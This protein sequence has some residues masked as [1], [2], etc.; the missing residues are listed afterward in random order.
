MKLE[1]AICD[2]EICDLLEEEALLEEVIPIA[3]K[4]VTW[5]IDMFSTSEDMI[6]SNKAYDWVFLDVEMG[7]PN[8]LQTAEMLHE[9]KK[10]T[11]IFF[12]THHEDYMDQAL[13][14]HAFRFWTK[15]MDK[16]RLEYGLKV[17]LKKMITQTKKILVVT[18]RQS[19]EVFVKDIIYLYHKSRYTH[20]VTTDGELTTWTSF[21]TIVNQLP[22]DCFAK[23]HASCC[24][25]FRYVK[26]YDKT[27]MRCE[28]N[29]NVYKP[30]F[31]VRK[32]SAFDKK[33]KD[34][35]ASLR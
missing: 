7:E 27:G 31:S 5:E 11:L 23:T 15:P 3:L 2:D 35:S 26:G 10:E 28:H 6:N 32:Y 4:G 1:I 20:L 30:F 25:N 19:T 17:A 21:K 24:V 12:V 16:N 13:D 18:E 8:G 34:W 9:K 29:G 14:N 22:D 33:F